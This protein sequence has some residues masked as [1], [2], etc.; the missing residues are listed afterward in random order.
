MSAL[1]PT[2]LALQYKDALNA[3]GAFVVQPDG[4]V[5]MAAD[6]GGGYA[7]PWTWS[8]AIPGLTQQQK[9]AYSTPASDPSSPWRSSVGYDSGGPFSKHSQWDDAEGTYQG[10]IDWG[11][12]L[13][14]IGA[15]SLIGGG[16]AAAFGGAGGAAPAAAGSSATV[17]S[18]GAIPA[19]ALGADTV[20]PATAASQAAAEA[21]VGASASSLPSWVAPVIK[22]AV[23]FGVSLATRPQTPGANDLSGTGL[24]PELLAQLQALI[25]MSMQR[26]QETAPVHQAAMLLASKLAAN[27]NSLPSLNGA[28]D[29]MQGP[30]P[31]PTMNP[32]V[33]A[34]LARLMGR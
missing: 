8:G 30:G 14:T 1:N 2:Q 12:L 32:N 31:S 25:K 7:P 4:R 28:R 16:V 22:G 18:S 19:A 29:A 24:S 27:Q 34:A 20:M 9:I 11:T 15:G 17:P 13:G 10:G 5:K 3:T 23:P 6:R 26:Q 33:S 21:A